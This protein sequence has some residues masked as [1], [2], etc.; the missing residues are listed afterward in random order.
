M[1]RSGILSRRTPCEE[2]LLVPA[3]RIVLMSGASTSL[4][5]SRSLS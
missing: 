5:E 3:A 2:A 4:E 1:R